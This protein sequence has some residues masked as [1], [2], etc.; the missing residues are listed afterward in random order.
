MYRFVESQQAAYPIELL[1]QTLK[2]SR[3]AW[4]AWRKGAS[5]R[6][7]PSD[8]QQEDQVIALF[9]KHRRRY[10]AR[11]LFAELQSRSIDVGYHRVRRIMQKH[12][13]KAIQPRSFVPRTTDSRHSYTISPNLFLDRC[14]P[15]KVNEVWVGDLT[16]IP[17]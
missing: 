14:F 7:T 17:L 3:S 2:V 9:G 5:H 13:L 8:K 10:G 1:C 4:Y 16:Y 12:G 11:R 6:I 15:D